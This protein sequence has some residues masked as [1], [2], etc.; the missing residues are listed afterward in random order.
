MSEQVLVH[1][2]L[3]DVVT[4]ASNLDRRVQVQARFLAERDLVLRK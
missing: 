2:V 3:Q 1:Q 4:L